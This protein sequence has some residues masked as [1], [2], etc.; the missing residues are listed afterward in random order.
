MSNGCDAF[1]PVFES[2]HGYLA[3]LHLTSNDAEAAV[4]L[5][6]DCASSPSARLGMIELLQEVNWRPTLVAAVAALFIPANP[7][8]LKN[9]WKRIDSGSWVVPQIA[10][11]LSIVDP[12]FMDRCKER[13]AENCPLDLSELRSLSALERHSAAGPAG[14]VERSAKAARA[15]SWLAGQCEPRPDWLLQLLETPEYQSLV[16]QDMD[17]SDIIAEQWHRRIMAI[18]QCLPK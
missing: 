5:V 10:V 16:A 1:A 17:S 13:L 14:G 8:I 12:D 6:R 2:P 7:D 15:L 9:L 4:R 11:T 18:L 3:L